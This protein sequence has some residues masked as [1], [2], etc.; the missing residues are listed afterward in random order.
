VALATKPF[1]LDGGYDRESVEA[2]P[3]HPDHRWWEFRLGD[4]IEPDRLSD[5]DERMVIC[6]ACYVPRCGHTTDP[7]PCVLPRHHRELHLFADGTVED[8]SVWPGNEKPPP[9]GLRRDPRL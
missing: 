1:W 8:S 4:V 9:P 7:N 3:H 6:S 2:C 5:P